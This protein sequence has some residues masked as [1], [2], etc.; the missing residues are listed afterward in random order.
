MKELG[1]VGLVGRF[2]PLH[3]GG[4]I[5]L[6]SVCQKAD[7]VIIGLGSS[8]KYNVRNP[9]TADESQAMI[10]L[11]LRPKHSNYEFV[12]IPDF[13]HH[14]EYGDGQRWR[15]YVVDS[16]GPLDHFVSGND[17]VQALL[18]NDYDIMHPADLIPK[19]RQL[20]LRATEVRVEMARGDGWKTLV[21][22]EVSRYIEQ[23]GLDKRFRQEF[24]L[25]TLACA[26][27]ERYWLPE[28]VMQEKAHTLEA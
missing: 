19:E 4:A 6:E 7:H 22:Y 25:H 8:N 14:P 21:P 23:N 17:Y 10:D 24:G 20:M 9:F 13:A 2:K 3:N 18:S 1:R 28:N 27:D 26:A 12:K 5:M 11:F 15:Q 16:M